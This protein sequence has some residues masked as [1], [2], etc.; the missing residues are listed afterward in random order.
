MDQNGSIEIASPYPPPRNIHLNNYLH[1]SQVVQV[2]DYSIWVNR[3]KKQHLQG[4]NKDSHPSPLLQDL[5]TWHT[6][7]RTQG[8]RAVECTTMTSEPKAS[9]PQHQAKKSYS[10]SGSLKTLMNP[11]F[12]LTGCLLAPSP[13]SCRLHLVPYSS[14]APGNFQGTK[15]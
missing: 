9:P 8:G 5:K 4:Q 10:G 12:R 1:R 3:K 13:L 6:E 15:F 7:G 11:G 2:R 14:K